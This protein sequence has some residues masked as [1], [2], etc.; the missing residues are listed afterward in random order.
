MSVIILTTE[1]GQQTAARWNDPSTCLFDAVPV[2]TPDQ[3]ATEL[4]P[5]LPLEP[6]PMGESHTTLHLVFVNQ[7]F[8]IC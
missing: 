5:N 2:A 8:T 6:Y 7:N 3:T 1:F 4:L